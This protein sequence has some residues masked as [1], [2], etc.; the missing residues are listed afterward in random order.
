MPSTKILEQKKDQVKIITEKLSSSKT[1]VLADFRG[2]TVE[3]VTELRSELRKA[4]VEYKVVK[5][6]LLRFVAHE[7]GLNELDMYFKAKE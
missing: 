1:I 4:G 7:C 3:Q 6:K 2:M 5:N